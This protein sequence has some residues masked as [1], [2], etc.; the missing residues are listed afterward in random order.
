MTFEWLES[1]AVL[2]A[3]V[4][5]ACTG[6]AVNIYP[7]SSALEL[8]MDLEQDRGFEYIAIDM[9]EWFPGMDTPSIFLEFKDGKVWLDN[10]FDHKN[11]DTR[12]DLGDPDTPDALT[13]IIREQVRKC[14]KRSK[15]EFDVDWTKY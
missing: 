2:L 12:Y 4:K 13:Y 11:R 7:R 3:I 5:E 14:E 8:E 6:F 9:S 15:K 10:G 1:T